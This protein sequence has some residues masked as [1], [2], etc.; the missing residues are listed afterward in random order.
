MQETYYPFFDICFDVDGYS[1]QKDYDDVYLGFDNYLEVDATC[2]LKAV[3]VNQENVDLFYKQWE[4]STTRGKIPFIIKMDYFG[5][6]ANYGIIQES[7]LVM[8]KKNG[9]TVSFNARIIFDETQI[10][11]EL[12]ECGA[13]TVYIPENSKDNYIRVDG[14]DPE[15]DPFTYEMQVPTAYG[16]LRGAPPAFL[17]TPD[18]GYEGTDCFSYT[19]KDFFGE[20]EPCVV[21]I[22]VGNKAMPLHTVKYTTTDLIGV[23]GN[24]FYSFTG[25]NYRRGFGGLVTP[26]T[27]INEITRNGTFND[28][29]TGVTAWDVVGDATIKDGSLYFFE[30]DLS[31]SVSADAS[32]TATF[33][34][35]DWYRVEIVIE[36]LDQAVSGSGGIT[37]ELNDSGSVTT[38]EVSDIGTHIYEVQFTEADINNSVIRIVATDA[39]AIVN[40]VRVWRLINTTEVWIKSDD[41]KLDPNY[42][43]VTQCLIHNWGVRTDFREYLLDQQN[44]DANEGFAICEMAGDCNGEDFS[45][46]FENT[47]IVEMPRFPL[48]TA[49]KTDRMFYKSKMQR[50]YFIAV[51]GGN[52]GKNWMSA[53]QMFAYSDVT[54][55]FG[56]Y[57]WHIRDFTEMY[58]QASNLVCIEAIN[59]QTSTDRPVIT[60]SRL[61][62]GCTSLLKP[63]PAEVTNIMDADGYQFLNNGGCGLIVTGIAKISGMA[64]CDVTTYGGTCTSTA[65]YQ[66]SSTNTTG[67]LTYDWIVTS[68]SIISGGGVND[69]FVEVS[70][71]SAN[72]VSFTIYARVDDSG[73][74]TWAYS[75]GY[76]FTHMRGRTYEYY[77]LPKYYDRI[78]LKDFINSKSPSSNEITVRNTK[79]NCSVYA[80]DFPAAWN[81]TLIND[82]ELQGLQKQHTDTNYS[83]NHGLYIATGGNLRFINN[84][85]VKGAGGYGGAGGKGDDLVVTSTDTTS[86]HYGSNDFWDV[87]P[88]KIHTRFNGHY[89]TSGLQSNPD[90]FTGP[91]YHGGGSDDYKLYRYGYKTC[92]NGNKRYS[93]YGKRTVYTTIPGG[94]SGAGGPGCCYNHSDVYNGSWRKGKAGGSTTPSGGNIGAPGANGGW[95]GQP[96]YTGTTWAHT[97]NGQVGY[98]GSP[99]IFGWSRYLAGS[100]SGNVMGWIVG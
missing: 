53:K 74:G 29:G 68:G 86:V 61:F 9:Y 47:S 38:P 30:E 26:Y 94:T 73:T 48:A 5:N 83:F 90:G 95:W 91:V 64:K 70:I 44:L 55:V 77:E 49:F 12:P 14:D 45:S 21:E 16:E 100:I 31:A 8:K 18:P 80:H 62:D 60:K 37:V 15:G 66:V 89:K 3:F 65:K 34:P 59:T 57:S 24:F 54:N 76:N 46:M 93:L 98:A 36:Q 63:S 88:D 43:N 52:T 71:T 81:V 87:Y 56:V 97:E 22:I 2:T 69:D 35:N 13:K 58:Y 10:S 4:E 7:P 51:G 1:L 82:G 40:R 78:N 85:W 72:E 23:S 42:Q 25:E 75:G 33:D 19:V 84:G 96:G 99:A 39:A 6:I 92:V 41:H 27:S 50:L 11:N 79:I 28:S 32:Q 17:Y 67:T 20:S